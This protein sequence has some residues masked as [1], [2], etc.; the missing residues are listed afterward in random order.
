MDGVAIAI[1]GRENSFI[2]VIMEQN[3]KMQ[4][5]L[6][7]MNLRKG[8]SKNHKHADGHG[9]SDDH[10]RRIKMM[11]MIMIAMLNR[12]EFILSSLKSHAQNGMALKM[13]G[14]RIFDHYQIL[15][16]FMY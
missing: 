11:I 14:D 3:K 1:L 15:C 6:D 4:R 8:L 10:D 7:W 2:T 12:T 16:I 13:K 9:P 5:I